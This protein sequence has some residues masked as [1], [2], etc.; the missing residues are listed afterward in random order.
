MSVLNKDK[1]LEAAKDFVVQ[2][3]FDKAIREY[4][5]LLQAD[6]A[7]MR[8][9]LR[10][11]ELFAK[12]RQV[13]QAIRSYRE[14]ADR[15]THEGFYLKAV[16]VL[17]NILRLNPS[18][19]DVNQ[20]LAELYEKMGLNKD[21][22][23]QYEILASAFEQQGKFAEALQIREKLVTLFPEKGA[24]R[25]RLAEAYQ[26][27]EKKEEAITQF[28]ILARQYE[29]EKKEADRLIDLYEKIIPHRPENKAMFTALIDLYFQKKDFRSAV[30]WLE[31][32]KGQVEGDIHLLELAGQMYGK[33]NQLETARGKYQQ[34][35][36]LLVEKGEVEGALRCY[37]AILI[38]LPEEAAT[39]KQEVERL[40]AGS[41]EGLAKRSLA[42]R[43]QKEAEEAKPPP[44]EKPKPAAAPKTV[45][46][47]VP[48]A[49]PNVETLLKAARSSL[50][51]F[52]AYQSAGLKEEANQEAAHA[53]EALKKILATEAGHTEAQRLLKELGSGIKPV[54]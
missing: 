15:Y 4:E 11:A 20:A 33:L 49:V 39:I 38:L 35:A 36:A 17:K 26:R 24:Y 31:Q 3:K 10:L 42:K 13:P 53:R 18:L 28:E 43:T 8:V 37:E 47:S 7:D 5:K 1:I 2:G 27:E 40:K 52:K 34:L 14:V 6:P 41:F 48:K 22:A 54:A 44:E 29:K 12:R 51:L 45:S 16:T 21:A 23:G 32:K 25:I 19:I 46:K 50:S 30:K 9:K